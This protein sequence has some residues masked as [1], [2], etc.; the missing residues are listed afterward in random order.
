MQESENMYNTKYT[1]MLPKTPPEGIVEWLK[2]K[3]ALGGDYVI[4]KCANV[5]APLEDRRRKMVECRCTAC[6][7]I[8]YN[9]Y[10]PAINKYKNIS[11]S[12]GENTVHSGD[13]YICPHCGKEVTAYHSNHMGQ[14]NYGTVIKQAFPLTVHNINNNLTL[15]CWCI[16]RR[17]NKYGKETI[18][19]VP[20]DG[21]LF[22]GKEK[23]RFNGRASGAFRVYYTGTW[24]QVKK[25][26]DKVGSFE[27]DMIY[28]F[29]A[30]I[31]NGTVA[32]NSKL[33]I[34]I[35][36]DAET[37]PVS[38]ISL[39]CRYP[40]IEN[41]VMSGWGDFLNYKIKSTKDY[42]YQFPKIGKIRGLKMSKTKPTEILRLNKAEMKYIKLHR[43]EY[44]QVEIYIQAK[45][46]GLTLE[47]ALEI[48]NKSGG[49]N[50]K[51]LIGT[52]AN[53][54]HA[55]RYIEK[56]KTKYRKEH[57]KNYC[58]I[59]AQYLVDYWEMSKKLGDDLSEN[60]IRYPH[61]LETAHDN[62]VKLQKVEEAKELK[63]KFERRY[64]ELAK[65]CFEDEGLSIHPAQ[66]ER[67]MIVEGKILSHCVG[68]YAK[69]HADGQTT[70]FFIRK[71]NDP[72]T[73]YF[74][75]EYDFKNKYILQNRGFKNCAPPNEVKA[76]AEKWNE[77]VKGIIDGKITPE[78]KG[79][80]ATK[81]NQNKKA[82]R[83]V[84]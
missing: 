69:S 14:R 33:D 20:Y 40:N 34:Y 68:S 24:R 62:A 53:I 48:I 46:Q 56:Q 35:A 37:Y 63:K 80:K 9:E 47:N 78:I 28:P 16:E 42:S 82:E 39:Y 81:K 72:E 57:K 54:P 73:P 45:S 55:L 15:L 52:G 44:G 21:Y 7:A 70:I 26:E 36:C 18:Q 79:K 83:S 51:P 3:D 31:L 71:T 64:R 65:Y 8:F 25:F 17:V 43:W 61:R 67:E 6:N 2:E 41:L 19:T 59:N 1:R 13:D 75:L 23:I 10:V 38:Y 30:N 77:R 29:D 32:E 4:Y 22:T 5:Y 49:F 12:D 60:S 66:S 76:F 50:I 84:A 74:T 27:V 11:F 58:P